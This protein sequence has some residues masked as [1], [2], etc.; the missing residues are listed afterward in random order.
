MAYAVTM[1]NMAAWETFEHWSVSAPIGPNASKS[2]TDVKLVQ[3]MLEMWAR[4]PQAGTPGLDSSIVE[5]LQAAVLSVPGTF[6]DGHYGPATRKAVGVL[7]FVLG[8]PVRD[9]I[10]RQMS[11]GRL[12]STSATKMEGLN[13]FWEAAVKQ[14][15]MAKSSKQL[16]A[17]AFLP[18]D[19]YTELYGS[20][21][22]GKSAKRGKVA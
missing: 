8:S 4:V 20:P 1:K 11:V 14:S 21:V 5:K 10:V 7:E 9:G 17:K 3:A 18:L 16:Q 22:A 2:K 6:V 19:V 13:F 15:G 12:D